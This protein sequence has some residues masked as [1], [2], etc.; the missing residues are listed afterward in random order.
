MF[1]MGT[2]KFKPLPK[3]YVYN[4]YAKCD[5]EAFSY[6]ANEPFLGG[7][8]GGT[9]NNNPAN[10]TIHIISPKKNFVSTGSIHVIGYG[11]RLFKKLSW[12]LKFD[13]KFLGRKAVK[14]RALAGDPTYVR[15]KLATELY[16]AVG[17]PVQEGSYARLI[18]NDTVFGLYTIIDSFSKKWVG[19]YIHGDEDKEIGFSYKLYTDLPN[20]PDFK[21]LGED[22]TLYSRYQP[23]EYEDTDVDPEVEGSKFER[24]IEFTRLFD[25]W[26]NTYGDDMSDTAVTELGKFLNIES[27]LR[28]LVID[29]LILALDNFWLRMSNA[30]LYYDP[31]KKKYLILPYDFDK[32]LLGST[33]D[34][35]LNLEE[36]NYLFD[37]FTWANQHEETV[38]HFFTNNILNH[39]QIKARYDVILA[40]ASRETFASDVVSQYIKATADLIREDIQWN[41]DATEQ[42]PTT[43]EGD[44]NHYTYEDF[45][46]NLVDGS[47]SFADGLIIND[48]PFGIEGF[49]NTRGNNCRAA[50]QTIDVS[51]NE[52]ISDKEE[53][54]IYQDDGEDSTVSS[55]FSTIIISN[56]SLLLVLSYFIYNLL[57]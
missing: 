23:D 17:V 15:E 55:A 32:V 5:E 24:I 41:I 8:V 53:V 37:C 40:K 3:D 30:S 31:D 29:T 25:Q 47:V 34:A 44:L 11:S 19:A 7:G 52:N 51:N 2:K 1:P 56:A 13:D 22:Y 10:C 12:G 48:A 50:T 33:G 39:P 21:Y 38:E 49:V 57:L 28:I 27:V 36:D 42:L 9:P 35:L 54:K 43:Y 26:I 6:I 18:I 4:I 20:Y 46:N 14:L 16:K 45:E